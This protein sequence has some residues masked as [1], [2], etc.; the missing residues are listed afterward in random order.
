MIFLYGWPGKQFLV[1]AMGSAKATAAKIPLLL[2]A[3][4][5]AVWGMLG[6]IWAEY[7]CWTISAASSSKVARRLD[8]SWGLQA[9]GGAGSWRCFGAGSSSVCH[10]VAQQSF[11]GNF[12]VGSC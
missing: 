10:G 11:R 4:P 1:A 8:A 9:G 3:S 5:R 7:L 2:L 6:A 12:G